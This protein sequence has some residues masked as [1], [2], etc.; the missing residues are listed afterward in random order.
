MS[1]FK[2]N[3]RYAPKTSLSLKQAKKS[4]KIGKKRAEKLIVLHKELCESA[5]MVQ[6]RIKMYYNKKRSE[7]PDLKKGDKV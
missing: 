5:E 6:R 2:T 7:G 4:S 1:P 3:Y